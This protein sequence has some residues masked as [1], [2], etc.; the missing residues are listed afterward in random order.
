MFLKLFVKRMHVR[1]RYDQLFAC[2]SQCISNP[3]HK[4]PRNSWGTDDGQDWI[5]IVLK[6]N[7]DGDGGVYVQSEE[8]YLVVKIISNRKEISRTMCSMIAGIIA[9]WASDLDPSA[10][11]STDFHF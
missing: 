2:S 6:M 10:A 8:L 3:F 7:P 4:I 1:K 5:F 11:D 9:H